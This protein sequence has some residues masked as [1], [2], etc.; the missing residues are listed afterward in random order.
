MKKL[1][2]AGILSVGLA[3][4]AFAQGTINLANNTLSTVGVTL[5]GAGNWYDGGPFALQ[6]WLLNGNSLPGD[7]NGMLPMTAYANLASD[8]FVQQ[9]GT[10]T[11]NMD[12]ASAG[13]FSFGVQTLPDVTAHAT[14]AVLALVGWDGGYADW[15]S[16]AAAGANGGVV[17]FVNPV[18]DP[19]ATPVPGLPADLTGWD[20]SA[21][22]LNMTPLVPEPTTIALG[23]LGLLAM[24]GLRR[25]K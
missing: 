17:A 24:L 18:G 13:T 6:V 11:M 25:R 4:G 20:S 19:N 7:I 8:G 16:A 21:L 23:G 3:V 10:F 9:L 12:A 14:E 2:L 1:V 22:D 5:N 15:A